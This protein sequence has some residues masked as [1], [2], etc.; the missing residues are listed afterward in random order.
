MKRDTLLFFELSVK[1]PLPAAA[2][3]ILF[4]LSTVLELDWPNTVQ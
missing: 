3:N 4:A 2:C 1:M